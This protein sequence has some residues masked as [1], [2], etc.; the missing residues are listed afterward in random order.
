MR[1]V[2]GL[3]VV[4]FALAAVSIVLRGG[5]VV[6]ERKVRMLENLMCVTTDNDN[7]LFLTGSTLFCRASRVMSEYRSDI[8]SKW[9]FLTLVLIHP[10]QPAVTQ[11]ITNYSRVLRDT[12]PPGKPRRMSVFGNF[13]F[14]EK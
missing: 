8:V 4:V 10:V 1:P 6:S 7:C 14:S 3:S 11:N 12:P 5:A 13:G 2:A 9:I